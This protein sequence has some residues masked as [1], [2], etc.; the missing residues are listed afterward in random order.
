LGRVDEI[1][2][3]IPP[4]N[5]KPLHQVKGRL[6]QDYAWRP[7]SGTR[8]ADFVIGDR[9]GASCDPAFAQCIS[10]TAVALG[11]S[12]A[13][14]M[15]SKCAELVRAHSYSA[16]NRHSVQIELNRALYMND[17]TREKTPDFHM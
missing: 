11:Y 4:R 8:R 17:D 9:Y 14:N 2:N 16:Q 1:I 6:R 13:R 15:P 12:V 5:T 10:D 7:T 3:A